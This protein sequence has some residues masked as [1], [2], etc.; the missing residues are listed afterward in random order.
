MADVITEAGFL[1]PCRCGVM[2]LEIGSHRITCR[3]CGASTGQCPDRAEATRRWVGMMA[4]G[5]LR[6]HLK[7]MREAPRDGTMILLYVRQPRHAWD[8]SGKPQLTLGCNM[9]D[10][11]ADDV[12]RMA[13]WDWRRD[14]ICEGD[15]QPIGW[16]PLPLIEREAE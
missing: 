4:P 13:G 12:W 1:P 8:E 9:R 5:E 6:R 16:L 3:H 14:R 15:G 10:N 11:Y 7:S 2:R